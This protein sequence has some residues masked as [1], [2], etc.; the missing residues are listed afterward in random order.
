MNYLIH[1]TKAAERDIVSAADYL[2]FN[3]CNP[4]AADELLDKLDAEMNSLSEYPERYAVVDDPVL[5]A[6]EI[7]IVG[8]NNYLAFYTVSKESHTVYLVRFLYGRR[9]WISILRGGISLN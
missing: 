8:I 9:D 2:E 6:W 3:L 4:Q 7:Q 1:I 5:K